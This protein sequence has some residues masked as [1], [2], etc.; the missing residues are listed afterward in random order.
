MFHVLGARIRFA[1]SVYLVVACK[2]KVITVLRAVS[3]EEM[4]S[5][6]SR[7][8]CCCRSIDLL[9]PKTPAGIFYTV[10]LAFQLAMIASA[11]C[12]S[13]LFRLPV[14]EAAAAAAASVAA[15]AAP[16]AAESAAAAAAAVTAAV[17]TEA[18]V[19]T[20][21]AAAGAGVAVAEVAV[22]ISDPLLRLVKYAWGSGFFIA[23]FGCNC[24]KTAADRHHSWAQQN[25]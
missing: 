6:N 21:A 5:L 16:V 13:L 12:P 17:T 4:G 1:S 8:F 3:H 22:G 7:L 2:N 18:A 11:Y 15:A 23:A 25:R 14:A 19:S 20:A 10:L 9:P 24:L